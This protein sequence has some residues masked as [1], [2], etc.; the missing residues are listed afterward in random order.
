MPGK[1]KQKKEAKTNAS[2]SRAIKRPLK[3]QRSAKALSKETQPLIDAPI[4]RLSTKPKAPKRER[5]RKMR[6]ENIDAVEEERNDDAINVMNECGL[7]F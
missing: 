7:L 3:G 5:K 1:R 2:A 6:S 4:Q